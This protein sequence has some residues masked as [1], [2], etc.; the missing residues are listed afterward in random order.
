MIPESSSFR[1]T[2][3][4]TKASVL[5]G[6]FLILSADVCKSGAAQSQNIA[7]CVTVYCFLTVDR[8]RT[9]KAAV[10]HFQLNPVGRIRGKCD[11][12]G[13][14]DP[15]AYFIHRHIGDHTI[16]RIVFRIVFAG[17]ADQIVI[18]SAPDIT[19]AGSC[20]AAGCAIGCQSVVSVIIQRLSGYCGN[21]IM[22]FCGGFGFKITL[23]TLPPLNIM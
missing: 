13:V 8:H 21:R 5:S 20:A 12:I 9:D 7:E 19:G 10:T 6:N 1:S 11:A 2:V 14:L 22:T 18:L 23:F 15:G 3:R 17:D 16:I 4:E